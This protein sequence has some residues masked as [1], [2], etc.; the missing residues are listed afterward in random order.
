VV[1]RF[2]DYVLLPPFVSFPL[3]LFLGVLRNAEAKVSLPAPLWGLFILAYLIGSIAY[4]CL[5]LGGRRTRLQELQL[6]C[7]GLLVAFLSLAWGVPALVTWAGVASVLVA[8]LLSL[9]DVVSRPEGIGEVSSATGGSGWPARSSPGM[10]WQTLV[11]RTPLPVLATDKSGAVQSVSPAFAELFPS[12]GEQD[13][14]SQRVERLLPLD[15]AEVTL[16]DLPWEIEQ[17]FFPEEEVL[18]F[19]LVPPR[20]APEPAP[21]EDRR[22]RPLRDER[23]GLYNEAYLAIRGMEELSRDARYK[24]WLSAVLFKVN[25]APGVSEMEEKLVMEEF[26]KNVRENV[27]GCDIGFFLDDRS[28]LLMLPETPLGG[29][30]ILAVRLGELFQNVLAAQS[31]MGKT[32]VCELLV[33][34]YFYRGAEPLQTHSLVGMLQQSLC[35][36]QELKKRTQ[37]TS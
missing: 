25:C 9:Y 16:N 1:N 26:A 7:Q 2:G 8:L 20:T 18:L 13:L 31:R 36:F 29:A 21:V 12:L 10:T 15:K 19:F 27:R 11:E 30:Q 35:P 33:G 28:I 34:L 24:R 3:L 37:G 4:G 6:F 14:L 22:R 32:I 17:V 23:T 5:R